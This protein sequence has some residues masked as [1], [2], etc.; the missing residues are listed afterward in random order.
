M[1]KTSL[2]FAI[3]HVI[4]S[5]ADPLIWGN[6]YLKAEAMSV[7]EKGSNNNQYRWFT[8]FDNWVASDFL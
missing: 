8:F 2:I 5:P 1:E 7:F 4:F 3:N 6:S